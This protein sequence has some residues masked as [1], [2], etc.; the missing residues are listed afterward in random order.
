MRSIGIIS[1][2]LFISLA[3]S[4][5]TNPSYDTTARAKPELVMFAPGIVPGTSNL[6]AAPA[7]APDGKSVY[8]GQTED[9]NDITIVVSY[10]V[11]GM[12]TKPVIAPF[13]GDYPNLEPAFDPHGK[14]IIFASSRPVLAG[15]TRL[16]G[17][18]AGKVYPGK[19]GNL[20]K[21]AY[22][23]K[24]WG[25]PEHLP[26][27]VNKNG[28]IFS[29]AVAGDGSLYFMRADSGS[30]FHIYRSEY[31]NGGYQTPVRASFCIDQYGD[32][33]PAVAPN[34][35][36]LIFSSPRP[37]APAKTA[38]LFIVFWTA[39]GWSE[40][41]DLREAVSEKVFGVEARL[42]PDLRTLYFTNQINKD[43]V[44]VPTDSYIWEVDI[45]G[46]LKAHGVLK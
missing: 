25:Q 30:V 37:P 29:P 6:V 14:Y 23:K 27:L 5:K 12:W 26:E 44:K 21:A 38:D 17:N 4:A 36:F 32:Y 40:P 19:G 2:C 3:S 11:G 24:G 31:K 46:L 34:Q 18:W 9:K 1:A 22:N 35:S 8:F 13:S 39:K 43:G 28:S 7:F 41:I 42:S 45:S 15:G 16:D 20:W 10:L 33:D